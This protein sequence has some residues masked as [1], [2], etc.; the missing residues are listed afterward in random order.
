MTM[1][2]LSLGF[3]TDSLYK[4]CATELQEHKY[5]I[6]HTVQDMQRMPYLHARQT[7]TVYAG[8]C[9][10]NRIAISVRTAIMGGNMTTA[11]L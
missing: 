10:I 4:L 11:R 5:S 9:C 3:A 8:R 2:I 7:S 1:L 6:K